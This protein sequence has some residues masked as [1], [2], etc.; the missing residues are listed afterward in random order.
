L[1]RY[2]GRPLRPERK[3]RNDPQPKRIGE[4]RDP[5]TV[6]SRHARYGEP[7]LLPAD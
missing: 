4:E 5:G 1:V 7:G 6:P 2:H 3:E